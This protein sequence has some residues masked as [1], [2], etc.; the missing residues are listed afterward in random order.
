MHYTSHYSPFCCLCFSFWQTAHWI[1][2]KKIFRTLL[3]F[4]RNHSQSFSL[5]WSKCKFNLPQSK[6]KTSYSWRFLCTHNSAIADHR[7]TLLHRSNVDDQLIPMHGSQCKR[8]RTVSKT[9]QGLEIYWN[10]AGIFS[11]RAFFPGN[12]RTSGSV[13]C[14]NKRLNTWL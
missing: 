3:R 7:N 1:Q 4:T 12:D 11:W 6:C 10:G 8:T 14:R 5:N 2:V 9:I 13:L